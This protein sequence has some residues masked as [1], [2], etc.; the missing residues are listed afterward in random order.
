MRGQPQIFESIISC[1]ALHWPMPPRKPVWRKRGTESPAYTRSHRSFQTALP[2]GGKVNS[3]YTPFLLIFFTITHLFATEFN[4]EILS[5]FLRHPST[6]IK[7]VNLTV[8]VPHRRLIV[9][10]KLATQ[11][12]WGHSIARPSV[13]FY[14]SSFQLKCYKLKLFS[15]MKILRMPYLLPELCFLECL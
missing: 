10:H 8:L 7:L 6:K 14:L 2:R 13:W 1:V 3:N 12:S 9:H 4:L 15:C 5:R 11:W